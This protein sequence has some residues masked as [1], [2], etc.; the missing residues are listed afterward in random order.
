MNKAYT[1]IIW[2]NYPAVTTP[3][4]ETNLNKV[5]LALDS[6][7]DR[8]V[9]MDTTKAN[10]TDMLSTLTNV[11]YN[12]TTGVFVFTWKN[13]NTL[14]A[15]LNIEKVPVDFSMSDAGV[16]TMTTADGTTFTADVSELIK[17]YTF[18][19]STELSWTVTTDDDGNKVVT[20]AL[21]DG[22]IA[23][24]KLQVNFLADCRAAKSGAESAKTV[25]EEKSLVS[26]GY[27]LGTQNGVAVSSTSPYYQNNAKYYSDKAGGTSLSG[28]SDVNLGT[29]S[30]GESLVYDSESGKWVNGSGGSN[31]ISEMSDVMIL[32]NAELFQTLVYVPQVGKW[33][34][35]FVPG[36]MSSDV[37]RIAYQNWVEI[38][39][40]II[41]D[42]DTVIRDTDDLLIPRDMAEKYPYMV[43]DTRV[44][45]PTD[46]V[47]VSTVIEPDGN[48]F[49]DDELSFKSEKLC[50]SVIF[51]NGFIL[52]AKEIPSF[53]IIIRISGYLEDGGY[54]G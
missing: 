22:S 46:F 38:P 49:T 31:K 15:D 39:E 3:L 23:E 6:V 41:T 33:V 12:E 5:D 7:D 36:A 14:T 24:S 27:A 32:N 43:E 53:D 19:N 35:A 1:R 11:T 51:H 52:L 21:I 20:A 50:E 4:N 17:T 2:E 45:Y 42:D 47:P 9:E 28:L 16:I 13:G 29:L 54:I 10:Q 34:N 40:S 37:Y 18:T 48:I 25:S 26:E 8:V 30:D 44:N